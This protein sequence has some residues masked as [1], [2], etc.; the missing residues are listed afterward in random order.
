MVCPTGAGRHCGVPH[1]LRGILPLVPFLVLGLPVFLEAR[2]S[3]VFATAARGSLIMTRSSFSIHD[4]ASSCRSLAVAFAAA[5]LCCSSCWILAALALAA[6]AGTLRGAAL[7]SPGKA[8]VSKPS[9]T[10][11]GGGS[12]GVGAASLA[13]AAAA[14]A[15]AASLAFAAQDL[16]LAASVPGLD[17][18]P[19]HR[20]GKEDSIPRSGMILAA[21]F[22]ALIG[23]ALP[24]ALA[25]P[26]FSTAGPAGPAG[27][28]LVTGGATHVVGA[29]AGAR[30]P[31]NAGKAS[32][33]S[34]TPSPG[35]P[36]DQP[37]PGP[38][39]GAG[40]CFAGPQ[41]CGAS[42][43]AD[44]SPNEGKCVSHVASGG[45]SAAAGA[46]GELSPAARPEPAPAAGL[47][48][49]PADAYLSVPSSSLCSSFRRRTQRAT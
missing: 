41:L 48:L 30:L 5:A 20:S 24:D 32:I 15:A 28:W 4:L 45:S 43:A 42:A 40:P 47:A 44:F 35:G 34:L 23:E 12:A 49:V 9:N 21:S 19:G 16:E 39:M 25:A 6:A 22:L 18:E 3:S 14:A 37:L 7:G 46:D 17:D 13:A 26:I 27:R 29:A 31:P 38:M 10:G 11:F 36:L 8:S 1:T 33:V 2:S